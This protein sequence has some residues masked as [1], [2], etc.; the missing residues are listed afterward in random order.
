[1]QFLTQKTKC[2]LA[3]E[4]SPEGRIVGLVYAHIMSEL[5][6][7]PSSVIQ[8]DEIR[9]LSRANRTAIL[10]LRDEYEDLWK[11]AIDIGMKKSVF[12]HP[13]PHLA[14]L[15]LL[16][17]CT[18]VAR[19][20]VQGGESTPEEICQFFADFSLKLLCTSSAYDAA[21]SEHLVER[22]IERSRGLFEKG[23]SV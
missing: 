21:I 12:E 4:S 1:M 23:I 17:M 8:D 13:E 14:R 16:G 10:R 6:N 11:D 22:C 15:A 9:S 5:E 7:V 2:V 18:Y 19:W 3:N 20:Y